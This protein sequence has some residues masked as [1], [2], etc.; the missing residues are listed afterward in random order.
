MFGN[1]LAMFSLLLLGLSLSSN[2]SEAVPTHDELLQFIRHATDHKELKNAFL[3]LGGRFKEYADLT[4]ITLNNCTPERILFQNTLDGYL[5]EGSRQYVTHW[6]GK[7]REVCE[8]TFFDRLLNRYADYLGDW[9]GKECFQQYVN[10]IE[11]WPIFGMDWN[12]FKISV[13][14]NI[15]RFIDWRESQRPYPSDRNQAMLW[16]IASNSHAY[17]LLAGFSATMRAN[18]NFR[19][20]LSLEHEHAVALGMIAEVTKSIIG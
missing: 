14:G 16:I 10:F 18:E 7:Q 6:V 2:L 1:Q 11:P 4:K 17:R 20:V 5:G 15:Q 9:G 3:L 19:P 13:R 8:M 12:V